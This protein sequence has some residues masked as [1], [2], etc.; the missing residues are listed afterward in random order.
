MDLFPKPEPLPGLEKTPFVISV[1]I[2]GTLLMMKKRE[3]RL[4]A[5]IRKRLY[6]ELLRRSYERG[7][8]SAALRD[9]FFLRFSSLDAS[10][11]LGMFRCTRY[12]YE[13]IYNMV[14]EAMAPKVHPNNMAKRQY[15]NRRVLSAD[16]K[17]CIALRVAGGAT[18]TDASWGFGVH[19]QTPRRI[20]LEFL[21]AVVRSEMGPIAFPN[22]APSLQKLAD[23]F[24]RTG[25]RCLLHHGCAGAG[26]GYPV[27]IKT[28]TL[29]ECPDPLS[30]MN[31][32]GFYSINMQ[33]IN[34]A[35]LRFLFVNLETNG[36]THD[37]TAFYATEF[38]KLF[39][40]NDNPPLDRHGRPFWLALD[41]AYGS[42][43]SRL[44]TP[45]PGQGLIHRHPYKD[46]FNY[47][48]SGGYRN[49]VE[50]AYGVMVARFGIFWRPI[51][52]DLRII[53]FVVYALCHIHNFLID[54]GK[55]DE[56]SLGTGMGSFG[57]RKCEAGVDM[58]NAK[59]MK[60]TG[61]STFLYCQKM[62]AEEFGHIR[63]ERPDYDPN[64][65]I[66]EAI[67]AHLELASITRPAN[68]MGRLESERAILNIR[69]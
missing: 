32:K 26:D 2:M 6:C 36:A 50:R 12:Q 52:L 46:S 54:C 20:F 27:R 23:A 30:Y 33:T 40:N 34:D 60:K 38:S 61:F 59:Q 48:L 57:S 18:M 19:A 14:G 17:I 68:M 66:R 49:V 3:V 65:S 5:Q 53:P 25:V 35:A 29:R 67:T 4:K 7:V 41:E 43:H 63:R 44:V 9:L 62:V 69:N 56:P 1:T 37:S 58:T 28:P 64:E 21:I 8:N 11:F 22:D 39:T 24:D 45:W 51:S 42:L 31:R 15:S 47:I 13:C 55:D 10:A 16:E